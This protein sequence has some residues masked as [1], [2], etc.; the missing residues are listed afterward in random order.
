M[1]ISLHA[2]SPVLFID[3]SYFIFYRYY[4]VLNWFRRSL[5]KGQTLDI[6]TLLENKTFLDKYVKKFEETI[7]ALVKTSKT[8][9]G[10]NVC[11]V[12]DCC[13]DKIWR[14]KYISGYKATREEKLDSFNKEIFVFTYNTLLPQLQEKYGFQ[15][16]GHRCLEA[17]DVIAI[18]TLALINRSEGCHEITIIT[19]D[20]DYIQLLSHPKVEEGCANLRI[21]NL[22]QKD[23]SLRVGCSPREYVL[24]K[25]ILGDKSDNIPPIAK[26]CGD[27]TSLKLARDKALL[28]KLLASDEATKNQFALNELLIDFNFIPEEL[29]AEI[30][31]SLE[32]KTT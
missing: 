24:V 32:I 30:V 11:F 20:N 6:G 21:V 19:N 16:F 7:C 18:M 10:V 5:A 3:T 9:Q 2:S 12:K 27:K 8:E 29:K 4:A 1:N 28:E 23:I 25:K 31:S 26:K 14:H 22:Q 13:R 15:V 17:D